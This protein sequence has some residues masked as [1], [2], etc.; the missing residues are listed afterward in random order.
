MTHTTESKLAEQIAE[1]LRAVTNYLGQEQFDSD[2]TRQFRADSRKLLSAYDTSLKHG[3]VAQPSDITPLQRQWCEERGLDPAAQPSASDP[4][5]IRA[6]RGCGYVITELE[7]QMC[8]FTPQCPRC[9]AKEFDK[10]TF[11]QPSPQQAGTP[12]VTDAD[13]ERIRE[14]NARITCRCGNPESRGG[15]SPICKNCGDVLP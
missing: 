2:Y 14:T 6:C 5:A 12:K 9:G 10:S 13:V 7:W 11:P 15:M 4:V 8:R 3:A 1:Q